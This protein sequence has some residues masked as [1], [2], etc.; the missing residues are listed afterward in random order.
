MTLVRKPPGIL[1]L[2]SSPL[3]SRRL[4]GEN[5][6]WLLS[7]YF[8]LCFIVFKWNISNMQK[9]QRLPWHPR[10]HLPDLTNM[11]IFPYLLHILLLRNKNL[12]NITHAGEGSPIPSIPFFFS[13]FAPFPFPSFP[14][15]LWMHL[16][17]QAMTHEAHFLVLRA[18]NTCKFIK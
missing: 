6:A 4:R 18:D 10:S 14:R 11:N 13:D 12:T 5:A 9:R 16:G 15:Q 1:W 8:L 3:V 7:Y 2:L 17:F